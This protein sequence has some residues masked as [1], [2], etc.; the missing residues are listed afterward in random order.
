MVIGIF[1]QKSVDFYIIEAGLGGR[2][3]STNIIKPFAAV[4]Q[5]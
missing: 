4:L 3:D 2:L 5:M 1:S